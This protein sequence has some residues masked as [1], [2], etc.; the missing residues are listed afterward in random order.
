MSES[1]FQIKIQ[2]RKP[3]TFPHKKLEINDKREGN[4]CHRQKRD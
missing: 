3:V 2:D 1:R 4:K